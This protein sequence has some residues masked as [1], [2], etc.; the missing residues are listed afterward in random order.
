MLGPA[1]LTTKIMR[2]V[3][4]VFELTKKSPSGTLY[5]LNSQSPAPL[6]LQTCIKHRTK[7]FLDG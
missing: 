5:E 4:N 1:D 2:T 3:N 6:A 7:K